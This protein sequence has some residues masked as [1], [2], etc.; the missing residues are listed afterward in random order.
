MHFFFSNGIVAYS[1]TK[2]IVKFRRN[3]TRSCFVTRYTKRSPNELLFLTCYSCCYSWLAD[4]DVRDDIIRRRLELPPYVTSGSLRA[5]FRHKQTGSPALIRVLSAEFSPSLGRGLISLGLAT[6]LAGKTRRLGLSWKWLGITFNIINLQGIDSLE[7]RVNLWI[8]EEESSSKARA[9]ASRV[10]IKI[11]GANDRPVIP[12]VYDRVLLA[13][14]PLCPLVI[15]LTRAF[16]SVPSLL[17]LDR[18]DIGK[19]ASEIQ[20]ADQLLLTYEMT[21]LTNPL[22]SFID[23]RLTRA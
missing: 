23:L 4:I 14:F 9:R 15:N 6:R 1:T 11:I 12:L 18:T 8:H 16:L 20:T 2:T 21:C 10:I 13:C 22:L 5:A 7:T 3:T 19:S 17:S